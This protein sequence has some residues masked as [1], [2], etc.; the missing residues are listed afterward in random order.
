[1]KKLLTLAL[2]LSL[3]G[4][5]A[6]AALRAADADNG[7]K[8]R[9]KLTEEQRKLRKEMVEKYDTNKDGKLD[10]AERARIS[11]GDKEKLEKAGLG[12]RHKKG[13]GHDKTGS[14]K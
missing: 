10:K 4:A 6:P 8:K 3:L 14:P 7:G 13:E 11:K 9:P 2:G 12:D 1:M 5:F